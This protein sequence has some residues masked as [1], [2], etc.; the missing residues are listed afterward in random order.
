MFPHSTQLTLTHTVLKPV[1]K[2]LSYNRN[3]PYCNKTDDTISLFT[4]YHQYIQGL[5]G[6]VNEFMLS[7]L[8]EVPHLIC[9]PE[10]HLQ[11]DEIINTHIPLYNLAA[12]YCRSKLKCGGVCIFIQ[13]YIKFSNINLLKFNKEQDL[14]INAV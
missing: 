8:P 6:K 5:K 10:H 7:L 1:D 2:V 14:E 4:I 13:E 11:L 3:S 9:L 12:K